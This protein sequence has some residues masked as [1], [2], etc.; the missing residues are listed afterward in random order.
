MFINL[1]DSNLMRKQYI[2]LCQ[3][4]FVLLNETSYIYHL[5]GEKYLCVTVLEAAVHDLLAPRWEHSDEQCGGGRLLI[6]C[7]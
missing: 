3:S 2:P 1:K 7:L 5:K 4:L 6:S